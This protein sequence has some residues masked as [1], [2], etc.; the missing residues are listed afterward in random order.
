MPA[1]GQMM[2]SICGELFQP[3]DVVVAYSVWP[4]ENKS[5]HAACVV[6]LSIEY[7]PSESEPEHPAQ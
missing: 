5:G 3:G 6:A 7:D 2:C 1:I 4:Q